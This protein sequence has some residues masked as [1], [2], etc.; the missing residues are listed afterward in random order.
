MV[1]VSYVEPLNSI[2]TVTANS[3]KETHYSLTKYQADICDKARRDR[4][5]VLTTMCVLI[6]FVCSLYPLASLM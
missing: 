4:R 1:T 6:G 2:E 5:A 3:D